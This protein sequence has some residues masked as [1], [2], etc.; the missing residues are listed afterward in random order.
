LRKAAAEA[1]DTAA[2]DLGIGIL[3]S[4]MVGILSGIW[5]FR[6]DFEKKMR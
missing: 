2:L 3:G 1:W 4:G 5:I 6:V